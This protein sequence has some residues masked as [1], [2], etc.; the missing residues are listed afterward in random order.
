MRLSLTKQAIA[1]L[2]DGVHQDTKVQGLVVKVNPHSRRYGVYISIHGRPTRKAIGPVEDWSVDAARHEAQ[3]IITTLRQTPKEKV[4]AITLREVL[5]LY[6]ESIT[7][8]KDPDYMEKVITLYWSHLLKRRLESVTVLE[9]ETH[10]NKLSADRGPSAA[11]YAITCLSTIYNY[12][13]KKE[14]LTNNRAKKVETAEATSRDVFLDEWEIA[15]LRVCLSE[16]A[17]NPRHYFLMVLLTG[18][19]R[20]NVATM[21]WEEIDLESALWTV[22]A[23]KSKNGRPIEIPLVD[24][25]VEI[26]RGR[27]S[28][29]A[30]WV[31]PSSQNMGRPVRGVDD[32]ANDLRRRMRERG[33]EKHFTIHDLRRTFASRLAA[34]GASLPV[35]AKALGHR[36]LS[37]VHVYARA[38]TETVR[39]AMG[40]SQGRAAGDS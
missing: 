16:M 32:W 3:R 29:D 15:Q 18:A 23:E 40:R 19:R 12:A 21:R 26:L 13:I 27:R 28:L 30:W 35:I 1:T 38:S 2:P 37:C 25:A 39:E 4:K 5:D 22:P 11:R 6:N 17:P 9:L 14:L 24:E 36:G 31:F 34:A 8:A 10:H 20:E 7:K 33:V